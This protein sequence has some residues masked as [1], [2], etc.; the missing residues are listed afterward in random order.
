MDPLNLFIAQIITVIFAMFLFIIASSY[1]SI[2][3]LAFWGLLQ[4]ANVE[5]MMIWNMFFLS[6]IRWRESLS[7]EERKAWEIRRIVKQQH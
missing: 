3:S 4:R 5:K 7:F 2:E 1:C 6:I